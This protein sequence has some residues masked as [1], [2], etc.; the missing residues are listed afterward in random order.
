MPLPWETKTNWIWVPN[1]DDTCDPRKVVLFRREVDLTKEQAQLIIRVS[2]DSRYRLFLNGHSLGIGPCK[3]TP[4][5]W[6]YEILDAT[7]WTRTGKNVLA[8]QVL[9]YSRLHIGNTNVMR[10]KIPGF[11]LLAESNNLSIPTDDRW[12]CIVDQSVSLSSSPMDPWLSINETVHGPS[13]CFGWTEQGLD[14]SK[15]AHATIIPKSFPESAIPLLP[16][17][18]HER[19]IPPLTE[20]PKRFDRVLHIR[21][22][23]GGADLDQAIK[24]WNH[25]LRH[26]RRLTIPPHSTFEI[27]LAAHEYSTGYLQLSFHGSSRATVHLLCAE[28]YAQEERT[29]GNWN[30]KKDD[31]MDFLQGYLGGVPDLYT[32]AGRETESYAPFWFWTFRVI[33]VFVK[34]QDEKLDISDLSY[35][36]TNYPLVIA[37]RFQSQASEFSAFWD[38]SLRTLKNCMHE[39]YE[40]CPYYEQSHLRPDGLIAMH[41]PADSNVVLPAFSLSFVFFVH[42]YL[43]YRGTSAAILSYFERR[44][45]SDGLVGQFSPRHWSFVDWVDG[46]DFGTPP[47]ARRG[48]GTYFSLVYAIALHSAADIAEF[49]GHPSLVQEFRNQKRSLLSA[50]NSC[51]FDGTWYYDGPIGKSTTRTPP[52]NWLSQHCQIYAILAGAIEGAAAQDLMRR[53]LH[54]RSLKPVSLAQKYYLFRALDIT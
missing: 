18:L 4:L 30:V 52:A 24:D 25:L 50:V 9:R 32:I 20:I 33:R 1:Y 45:T 38:I 36:E 49:L 54:D 46:W 13:R 11:I 47:A 7:P 6:N 22:L 51:C 40:D 27:D 53:T 26:G 19:E 8:A 10:A 29:P 21:K 17:E 28:S 41:Y 15:W 42:D 37:A 43:L 44:L 12:R 23:P 34:T 39:T 35:L 48:P 2:A 16:W 5:H 14:D 3:G 31:R